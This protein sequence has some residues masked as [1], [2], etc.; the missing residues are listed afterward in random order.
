M[1]LVRNIL[2]VVVVFIGV[3]IASAQTR[4]D[5]LPYVNPFIGQGYKS[6]I[7]QNKYALPDNFQ[8]RVDYV[9]KVSMTDNPEITI[10]IPFYQIGSQG[11]L[12]DVNGDGGL[13]ILDVVMM[14]GAII[15]HTEDELEN[16]DMNNDG[17]INVQDLI[18][19]VNQILGQ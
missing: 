18:I 4:F 17:I 12:G 16:A 8:G 11:L 7:V 15:N 2:S 14:M 13:N 19:L 5:P 3:Q 9:L 6:V 10:E 1:F